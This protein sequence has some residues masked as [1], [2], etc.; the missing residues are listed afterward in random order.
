[1]KL[2]LKAVRERKVMTQR[3]LAER[4]NVAQTTISALEIGKQ[5]ARPSTIRKLAAA[6]GVEPEE[7]VDDGES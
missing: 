7:L 4:S 1:M 6:L 2:R 3:E 5:D